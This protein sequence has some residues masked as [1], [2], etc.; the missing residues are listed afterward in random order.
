MTPS[1][2]L[3]PFF[4]RKLSF[5]MMEALVKAMVETIE[6]VSECW[7]DFF[8]DMFD[9]KEIVGQEDRGLFILFFA[10]GYNSMRPCGLFSK[11]GL[12]Y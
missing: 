2:L 4:L 11:P 7:S 10:T 3:S 1:S 12:S 6:K 5:D 9:D 8:S